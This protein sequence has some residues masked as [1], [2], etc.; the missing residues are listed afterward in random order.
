[1]VRLAALF[2]E[3]ITANDP[4]LASHVETMRTAL[5]DAYMAA[6]LTP[7]SYTD[8]GSLSGVGIKALLFN[9]LREKSQELPPPLA[10]TTTAMRYY[11]TDPLGSVRAITD[12]NG[13][14]VERR[15]YYAFG[16]SQ[17]L[18][19]N[20]IRFT[21]KELDVPNVGLTYFGARYYS[22]VDARFTT[23]DPLTD[24]GASIVDPQQ[25]NRYAYVLNDP[26]TLVDPLGLKTDPCKGPS[27]PGAFY[28][29]GVG[30]W[31]LDFGFFG[32]SATATPADFA[33]EDEPIT[34][35]PPL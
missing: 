1:M 30:R 19:G 5:A 34:D 14:Q 32:W 17:P 12:A 21:G 8:P 3:P 26:E 9:Q 31:P 23:V 24:V 15:D 16:D 27:I 20:P 33:P 18:Q 4:I 10:T 7:P 35:V 13:D 25:W 2:V 6:E 22:H 28:V 29:C 11:H